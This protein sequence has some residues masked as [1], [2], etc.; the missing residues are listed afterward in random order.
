MCHDFVIFPQVLRWL[1]QNWRTKRRTSPPPCH[2]RQTC[3]IGSQEIKSNAFT[4]STDITVLCGCAD[5]LAALQRK[6]TWNP[7]G[8]T[9]R[10]PHVATT[11]VAHHE[12]CG[13]R[14]LPP[15]SHANTTARAPRKFWVPPFFAASNRFYWKVHAPVRT[16]S[17]EPARLTGEH[18]VVSV[19][20]WAPSK[21]GKPSRTTSTLCVSTGEPT[22][23]QH[24][25]IDACCTVVA[26]RVEWTAVIIQAVGQRPHQPPRQECGT[27]VLHPWLTIM[28]SA[29]R[30]GRSRQRVALCTRS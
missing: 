19:A 4:P 23:T 11:L 3:V 1:P 15:T 5:N 17:G 20:S 29:T 28:A 26:V 16:D 10:V 18:M 24:S 2:A 6:P 14:Q 9:K 7:N 30:G 22:P 8:R 25:H 13:S 27:S 21:S 12:L